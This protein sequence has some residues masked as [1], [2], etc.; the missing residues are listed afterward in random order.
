MPENTSFGALVQQ[1][2]EALGLTRP[3]LAGRV[4]AALVTV[5][6]IE[7]DERRPSP[8]LAARLAGALEIPESERSAFLHAARPSKTAGAP[9]P[10]T[11][12][13]ARPHNLPAA[14]S[15]FFGREKEL[16]E[17]D[18]LLGD[19]DCRLLTLT[20]LGGTGKSRLALQAA[21]R[22]LAG[23]RW[24]GVYLVLLA[25]LDSSRQIPMAVAAALGLRGERDP[26]QRIFQFLRDKPALLL[27]DNYEHLI[28]GAG[29]VAALLEN[30]PST[31]VLVTSRERLN[32]EGEWVLPVPGLSFPNSE[33]ADLAG[34]YDAIHLFVQTARRVSPDFSLGQADLPYTI[35]ICR[36]VEGIPLAI[37]MA[38]ARTRVL[39]PAQIAG[40]LE[41]ALQFLV[42]SDPTSPARHQTMQATLDWSYRLLGEAEQR[43][44]RRLAV[45]TGSFP[46]EAAER[47]YAQDARQEAIR[48]SPVLDLLTGL[49]DKSLL[50]VERSAGTGPRFR[51]LEPVKQYSRAL[52]E[53]SGEGAAARDGLLAWAIELVETVSP[54][55]Y[56]AKN[57]AAVE[58]L[59]L[60]H[61]NL[62]LAL[63]WS[64][65]RPGKALHGH[66]LANLLT[67]FWQMSGYISEGADWFERLLED[68]TG[69]PEPV[70]VTSLESA[71]FLSTHRG[72]LA[73]TKKVVVQAVALQEKMG[74]R[75][76]IA[77]LKSRLGWVAMSEGELD[78]ALP[79]IEEC[80]A[81][82]R[83]TGDVWG[84]ASDLIFYGDLAFLRGDFPAA[85]E[86]IAESLELARSLDLVPAIGRRLT[87]MGMI[88][89]A[90]GDPLQAQGYFAASLRTGLEIHDDWGIAM[91]LSGSAGLALRRG[92]PQ[93]AAWLLGLTEVYLKSFEAEL[94][95]VDRHEYRRAGAE[96]SA[97]L[98]VTA[99]ERLRDEGAA[100]GEKDLEGAL[101]QV[102]DSLGR[103]QGEK[104]AARAGIPGQLTRREQDV[105]L[106]IAQGKS[107]AEIAAEL[108]LGLRTVEAHV[109][110]ILNKLGF[111]S[112]AQVAAWA[113]QQRI[114]AG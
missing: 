107:N 71:A 64:L 86:R 27:L 70:L 29:W 96:A 92:D 95:P 110:H 30:T 108:F 22:Q 113:V 5:K 63:E 97:L 102:L 15:P 32:L 36:S 48:P 66:R 23:G 37:E 82:H 18:R 114:D 111:R 47:V 34:E 43:L 35:R 75:N 4:G 60:E 49:V 59:E 44:F 100:L 99:F 31:R 17:I 11:L 42:S 93:R 19:P 52:L 98:G 24:D 81:T 79:L 54:D 101:Q 106:R 9:E 50:E 8:Q 78:K 3:E 55:V 69:I 26:T 56:G 94:W 57:K 73:R 25:S 74:G 6:K 2:R 51:F 68:T 85:R 83:E 28:D 104:R 62:R 20:G 10:G 58:R 1:R 103:E 84:I 38:A 109:T 13:A 67:Q 39:S 46:L 90:L 16:A 76:R 105:A 61:A 41:N 80:L 33:T 89:L 12:Q 65:S 77:W 40:R 14:T 53:E 72:D 112:R 87:R 45:F 88:S 91:A 21:R 7:R